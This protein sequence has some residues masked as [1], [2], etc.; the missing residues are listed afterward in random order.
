M[1]LNWN[2]GFMN[3]ERLYKLSTFKSLQKLIYQV[4][5]YAFSLYLLNFDI[6]GDLPG[7]VLKKD[8]I[9]YYF[10]D[11]YEKKI[12]M[13]DFTINKNSIKNLGNILSEL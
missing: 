13:F 7:L 8:K 12:F 5:K 4:A 9:T 11:S 2:K 1:A 10:F 6:F 3:F